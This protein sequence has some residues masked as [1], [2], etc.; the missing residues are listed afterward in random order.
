M[1]KKLLIGLLLLAT[2]VRAEGLRVFYFGNSLTGCSDPDWH[3]ELGASAGKEWTAVASLGAGWQLWQHRHELQSSGVSLDRGSRGDLTIPPE[4]VKDAKGR[5]RRFFT[6]KWDAVVLQ[7]F[8]MGLTWKC[9]EMWGTKF[10][11]ET[12]VGDIASAA[13]IIAIYLRLNPQ[14][15]V[16]IYQNW[17]AMQAGKVP[18]A[19]QLPPWAVKMKAAGKELRAAE[20]PDRAGFD[21]AKEWA[22]A[23]HDPSPDPT[24]FWLQKNAR[25][26]DYHDKLFAALQ[27][28]CPELWKSGRLRVIP[29]ADIYLALHGKMKSGQ[30]PGCADVGDFYTDVQHIRGGLPRYTVAAAF[31]ASLFDEPPGKLDWKLYNSEERYQAMRFQKDDPH[32]DRGELFTITAERAKLV[33]DTIWEVLN[34]HP[35]AKATR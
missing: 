3:G 20:F 21:Y 29:V 11:Q 12:D 28:R 5:L 19:D 6:E 33:N 14:G 1:H 27:A 2:S 4:Q 32:H 13:D 16:F 26:K 35:H 31:Y 7:P 8:S 25:S 22:Q 23:Q 34:S 9:S 10:G 24:K 15:K 18:P 30:F 17:P